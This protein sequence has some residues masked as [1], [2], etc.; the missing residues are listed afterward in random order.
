MF[1]M[2]MMVLLLKYSVRSP[3]PCYT[4][5]H[6]YLCCSNVLGKMKVFEEAV[7]YVSTLYILE[8]QYRTLPTF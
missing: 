7:I 5:N 6:E 3:L 2:K 1:L 4:Y 8:K